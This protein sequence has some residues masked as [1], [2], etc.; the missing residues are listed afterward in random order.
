MPIE[1]EW[2][3][4]LPVLLATYTGTIT[5][6]DYR[7]ACAR[8]A[9]MLNDGPEGAI[10]V[11]NVQAFEGFPAAHTATLKSGTLAHP[12]VQHLLVVFDS[13]R[14]RK[15][16]RSTSEQ[17]DRYFPVYIF[18]DTNDALTAAQTLSNN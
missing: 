4:S 15:F 8:C 16:A 6:E 3:K 11:A 14:Y 12:K 9:E 2:H 17:L 10:V 13:A 18:G 7:A 5:L 1:L